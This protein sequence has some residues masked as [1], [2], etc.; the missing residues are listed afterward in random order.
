[1]RVPPREKEVRHV[2]SSCAYVDYYNPKMARLCLRD[3]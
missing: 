3:A 1:M 2:C